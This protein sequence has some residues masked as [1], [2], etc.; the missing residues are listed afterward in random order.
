VKWQNELGGMR[1]YFKLLFIFKY[2]L[3]GWKGI[4]RLDTAKDRNIENPHDKRFK[5][6]FSDKKSFLSLLRDCV[7]EDW[8]KDINEDSLK[9]SENS[10]ILQD[11]SEQEADI[12]YEAFLDGQKVVFYI[13]LE[14][15]SSVDYRMPYRLLL[16]I[17]EIL[18]YYYNHADTKERKTKDFKFPAV[19]PIV[20]YSGGK[21]W[22]VPIHL[23]EMFD[24]YKRFGRHVLNFDYVLLDAKGFD[25]K[26]LKTFSSRL[27]AA[28][29]LLEKSENDVEVYDS[30]RR[31]LSDIQSFNPEERRIFEL[32]IKILDHLAYG[33]NRSDV[34][35]SLIDNR[36]EEVDRMLCD[37]LENAKQERDQLFAEG[38]LEGKLDVARKLLKRNRPLQEI[39]EDTGLT[40]EEIENF[41]YE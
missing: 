25:E 34:I 28:I 10:F 15:Q 19:F 11:F 30:V 2:I 38:K 23:N 21:S 9:K 17:V 5:E 29:L 40:R 24:G 8:G 6:L 26:D 7:K 13:L 32:F 20:F 27:L 31:S 16:Y 39:I 22:T 3:A 14:L 12:V 1:T 4:I 35:K 18:R 41:C 37:L 33:K 36:V